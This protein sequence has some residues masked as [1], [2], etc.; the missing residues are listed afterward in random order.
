[1]R[2]ICILLAFVGMALPAQAADILV[3][4]DKEG[5]VRRVP[6]D[7]VSRDTEKGFAGRVLVSGRKKSI[8][9]EPRQII[10]LRRGDPDDENQWAKKLSSG[11]RLMR[12]GKF[13]TQGTVAGAEETFVRVAYTTEEGIRGEEAQYAALPWHNMYAVFYLI[14]TRLKMAQGGMKD[15]AAEGLKTVE[16]FKKRTRIKARKK[17]DWQLPAEKGSTREGKVYGWGDTRLL[18]EVSLLEAQLHAVAGDMGTA[19]STFDELIDHIGKNDLSPDL[20]TRTVMAKANAEAAGQDPAKAEEVFRA[21]GT[22][23][24]TMARRQPNEYGK[25]V[26]QRSANQALLRGADLLLESAAKSDKVTY[27]VPL[28]RYQQL[29][30]AEGRKDRSVY[31]G[32][33]A[34]IG[35]CLVET[36]KGADA[37]A[38]LL[39]VVVKG[40][41]YP[42]AM[43]RSLYYLSRASELFAKEIEAGG[44]DGSLLRAEAERWRQDVRERFP[45]SEWA[46]KTQ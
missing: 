40:G 16:E 11:L 5:R 44:G 37:Y 38:A 32:A 2:N 4:V 39:E 18:S 29:Q 12:A 14:E 26:L 13:A 34:G 1:M 33:Q 25:S 23:L 45:S 7:S 24:A 8:R 19:V 46:K 35:T 9:L 30:D 10:E 31:V 22:R 6:V 41:D 17:V 27:D 15:K 21:A 42:K 28:R 3:Y 36:G 20:L 43:A